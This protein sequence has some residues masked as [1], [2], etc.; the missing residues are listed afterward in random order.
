[1][2]T[3]ARPSALSRQWQAKINT[4][5]PLLNKYFPP[6]K[7][8]LVSWW[9]IMEKKS[10]FTAVVRAHC[11]YRVCVRESFLSP[12][13]A[14]AGWYFKDGVIFFLYN[15]WFFYVMEQVSSREGSA[16]DVHLNTVSSRSTI[17]GRPL[18]C[19]KHT[20]VCKEN[21][22]PSERPLALPHAHTHRLTRPWRN[23]RC[24]HLFLA[25]NS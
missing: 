10:C 15:F 9:W 25:F 21:H 7:M 11:A 22:K 1:M 17:C 2:K 12:A 3:W 5:Y 20:S 18:D 13:A 23:L 14:A 19:F 4:R 24:A 8:L 6:D 16:G